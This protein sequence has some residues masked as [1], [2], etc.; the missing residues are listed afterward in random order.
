VTQLAE[1]TSP[2]S[3]PAAVPWPRPR[4]PAAGRSGKRARWPE[5]EKRGW[6][7][8]RPAPVM[9]LRG[10]RRG[11]PTGAPRSHG[12]QYTSRPGRR[13]DRGA[14]ARGRAPARRDGRGPP[15]GCEPRHFAARARTARLSTRPGY[16]QGR[17]STRAARFLLDD[18][19]Q[20]RVANP[21]ARRVGSQRRFPLR[22]AIGPPGATR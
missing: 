5:G 17:D 20:N 2:G 4:A 6:V 3:T 14:R 18:L 13:V 7:L 15:V 10:R 19:G 22:L 21:S 11:R 12:G 8:E 9:A 16:T 1:R